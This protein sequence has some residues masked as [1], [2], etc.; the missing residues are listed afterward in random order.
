MSQMRFMIWQ[1]LWCFLEKLR[2]VHF[3]L[4]LLR[5]WEKYVSSTK[6]RW[7]MMFV[8]DMIWSLQITKLAFV[9]WRTIYLYRLQ[10]GEVKDFA[11]FL[12]FTQSGWTA[13]LMSR[14]RSRPDVPI[15]AFT[16]TKQVRDR[17]ALSFRRVSKSFWRSWSCKSSWWGW[18]Y[19]IN[20]VFWKIRK[21]FKRPILNCVAWRCVGT[22]RWDINC[23]AC[24]N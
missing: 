12:V 4:K 8:E 16:H 1:M 24:S 14:Y 11:G 21:S 10:K 3:L 6:E 7:C 19:S 18:Y 17:L 2:A 9:T 5:Q 13:R 22:R 15:F 20:W 23:K